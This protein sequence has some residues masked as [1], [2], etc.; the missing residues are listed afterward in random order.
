MPVTVW[1][2]PFATFTVPK[3]AE[4]EWAGDR[5]VL[6]KPYMDTPWS[7]FEQIRPGEWQ[8]IP[9]QERC[10]TT[11]HLMEWVGVHRITDEKFRAELAELMR[12]DA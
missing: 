11:D 4:P 3:P 9:G 12:G 7:I 1:F 6:G 8:A 5:F 10:A 2:A